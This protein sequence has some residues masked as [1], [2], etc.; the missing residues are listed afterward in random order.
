M[1]IHLVLDKIHIIK[2][3]TKRYYGILYIF[4][5]IIKLSLRECQKQVI[6]QNTDVS[7]I[8]IT[9]DNIKKSEKYGRKCSIDFTSK[10]NITD[11]LCII[12]WNYVCACGK[13]MALNN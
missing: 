5:I 10:K 11:T 9:A 8:D 12:H 4:T 2:P 6:R 3:V 13:I 1:Q 7:Y